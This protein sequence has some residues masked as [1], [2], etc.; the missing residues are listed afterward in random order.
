MQKYKYKADRSA[1]ILVTLAVWGGMGLLWPISPAIAETSSAERVGTTPPLVVA[2][3]V[4]PPLETPALVTPPLVVPALD[5]PALETPALSS[6]LST[7]TQA[8]HVAAGFNPG[9]SD[10]N[11][12]NPGGSSAKGYNPAAAAS[13]NPG[14]STIPTYNPGGTYFPGFNPSGTAV[15]Y[16][17]EPVPNSTTTTSTPLPTLSTINVAYVSPTAPD[18]VT[19]TVQSSP[20]QAFHQIAAHAASHH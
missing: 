1:K 18:V 11:N 5:T 13:F 2:S 4:I 9:G 17:G 7:Q 15:R 8:T 20:V 3:L 16:G 10:Q 14:T 19:P 6:S 12:F